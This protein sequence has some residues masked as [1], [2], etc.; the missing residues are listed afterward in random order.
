MNR[1]SSSGWGDFFILRKQ[2]CISMDD[3]LKKIKK[4]TAFMKKEGILH[5]KQGD[6]ELNLSPLAIEPPKQ[7]LGGEIKD[8]S[9]VLTDMD[10][11]LWSS[12]SST[13]ESL[14]G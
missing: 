12:P 8:E 3:T 14:N 4:L 9:P 2:P 5:L 7:S 1:Y 10:V 6:I 13:E 11:L